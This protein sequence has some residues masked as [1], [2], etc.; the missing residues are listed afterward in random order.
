MKI[1]INIYSD[2]FNFPRCHSNV[3]KKSHPD[4][5]TGKK[6]AFPHQKKGY[7]VPQIELQN[8]FS[9]NMRNFIRHHPKNC[10]LGLLH[11]KSDVK[12]SLKNTFEGVQH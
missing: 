5:Y 7:F 11:E 6:L 2:V 3:F 12:N 10:V 1:S 8:F 9:D 4:T